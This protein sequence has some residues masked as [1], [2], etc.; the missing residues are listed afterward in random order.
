MSTSLQET[1]NPGA[2][3]AAG[4]L[5]TRSRAFD[6][7][8]RQVASE[9]R[10]AFRSIRRAGTLQRNQVLLILAD[11][12]E[13][14]A[15]QTSLLEANERDI[16]A[17][18]SNGLK[19]SLLE[20]LTLTPTRIQNMASSLREIAGLPDPVGQVI[21]GC[22]LP[23]GLE[24]TKVRVPL[25][26]LFTI[27]ESR[28]NVTIDVGAL[29]IKSGNAAI[30]RGGKEAVHSNTSLH[31]LFQKA[32]EAAGLPTNALILV[33]ETDRAFMLAL[34]RREESIDLVVPRGGE[35]LIRFITEHS[36]IPVVKHD[37]GV[38]NLYV[39]PSGDPDMAAKIAINSK[40]QRTS[41]CNSLENL[42]IDANFEQAKSLLGKLA[43][44]GAV[45]LG[46]EETVKLEPAVQAITDPDAEY[47]TEYLDERLSVKI[48]R[49]VDEA[50]DFIH[51][52][53][54]GHSE[55]IVA[56]DIN[57]IQDFRSG[58]DSAAVFV[59]CST[60]FHDGGQM[61]MGA[62][63]GISTGR[64]HVRGPMGLRDLTTTT[65]FVQGQGQIRE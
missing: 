63:V 48:V 60:R 65:Y 19:P 16:A 18:H 45:L 25:G 57:A 35:Q 34:L 43:Q 21:E 20:R 23:N 50:I 44:A 11:L 41:V 40:L 42:L 53:G 29:A 33:R 15:H 4:D 37:K 59:N 61:G 10:Q 8:A 6:E 28:P 64:L 30:L 12:L 26:V 17:G 39:H 5:L 47:A 27:Y 54:S 31:A 32:L 55:A 36:R 13:K 7:D 62:E 22:R 49:G 56:R 14:P 51:R 24:Q 1:L 58:V 38:C 2:T 9:A 3:S 52:Y 46:C